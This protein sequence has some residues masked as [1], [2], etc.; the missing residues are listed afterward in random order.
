MAGDLLSVGRAAVALVNPRVARR[1]P[2][3][4]D[5]WALEAQAWLNGLAPARVDM[6]AQ[7]RGLHPQ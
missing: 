5:R 6:A 2:P 1:R 3:R 7:G 4:T